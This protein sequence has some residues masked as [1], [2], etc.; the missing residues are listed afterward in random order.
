MGATCPAHLIFVDF[1]SLRISGE[2]YRLWS[3][4]LFCFLQP[5][6]TSLLYAHSSSNLFSDLLSLCSFRSVR[7]K[8]SYP[9][10]ITRKIVFC[11]LS[12]G[13]ERDKIFLTFREYSFHLLLSFPNI[14]TM[15]Y[16][17]RML[18]IFILFYYVRIF[19]HICLNLQFITATPIFSQWAT[20]PVVWTTLRNK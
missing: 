18:V 15:S 5:P 6:V 1:I 7:D 8:V 14:W 19:C 2:G 17:R 13:R 4:S 10:K 3:S 20:T 16:F 12:D 9:H 11:T